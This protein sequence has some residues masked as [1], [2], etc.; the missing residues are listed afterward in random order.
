MPSEQSALSAPTRLVVEPPQPRP[1]PV[2]TR[3]H[4]ETVRDDYAWLKAPNWKEVLKD[5]SRLPAHIRAHLDAENLYADTV[6]DGTG[7]LRRTLL[8]EMRGRIKEDD[9]TVPEVD[10]PFAYFTCYRQGG[11]H[12]DV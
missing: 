2:Y 12:P 5:G 6:L 3:L 11:Q 10:G 8:A 1:N 7:P 9:A 4:G